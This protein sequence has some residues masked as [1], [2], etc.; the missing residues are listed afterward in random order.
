MGRSWDATVPE[1]G[2]VSPVGMHKKE[3][4]DQKTWFHQ[5][6]PFQLY[7][8]APRALRELRA[9]PASPRG[10]ALP[11]SSHPPKPK[12]ASAAQNKRR[13]RPL[14][15]SAAAAGASDT[16]RRPEKNTRARSDQ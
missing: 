13:P 2:G 8:Q 16:R 3:K 15:V 6:E 1:G 11:P 14:P 4:P 10:A 5:A 9:T 7:A 12:P